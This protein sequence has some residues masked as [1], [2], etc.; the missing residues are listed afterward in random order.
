[1]TVCF[2]THSIVKRAE[3][4]A[5]VDSGATENFMNLGYAKW[6]R[7]PIKRLAFKQNL[8]NVDGMEN[9]SG[10]LKYYTDL[11][12]QMG[13][14]RV[15]M[16]FFL[17]DLGEHKV[18]LGYSWFVAMQPKIDWKN[19]WIDESQ[20]LIILWTE[21]SAKATYLPWQVN[22]PHPVH[23]DRYFLGKVM[24]SQATKD[25]M[26]GVPAEYE[27]HAKI[28]SEQESQRLPGHMVWDHAIELLPSAPMMLPGWLLP[29]TQEEIVEAQKFV[30]RH[31]EWGIIRPSWSPYAANFF[32]I[33]KKDGKLQPVQDYRL[34]NKWTKKNCNVSP[35]ILSVIDRLVGCTLFTK[36]DIQWGY[37]NIWIKPGDEWKA[38]FLTPEGLFKPTVMF[39]GLTNSPAIFQMM[40]NTIFQW[41]VQE[42]WFS[43]FMD[44]SIIY[45]KRWSGESKN[46]HRQRHWELVHRIFDILAKN[47]LYIKPEK[48]TFEQEEIEYLGIIVGKGKT[49]MDPKKLMAVANYLTLTT[50]TEVCAFLGLMGY[51]WYFIEGYSK[52]VWP[53]LDLMKKVEAWHWDK[54]QEQAFMDLKTRMCKALVLTQLNFNWKFYLQTDASGYSMG[55]ILLQEGGPDTLTMTLEQRKKLV[56]HPI[57]Y[58]LATFMPTQWNYD[59]YNRELLAIMMALDH[60]RQYL[61]WTKVLFTIMT[62]HANLQ[63]WK[64]PQNLT[65]CTVRWHLDLQEYNYEILYSTS[66]GKKMNHQMHYHNHQEWTKAKKITRA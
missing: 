17:M 45:T 11:E 13:A 34:V 58:Y 12:V 39:F 20:L 36:F 7:L 10:K 28:F 54:E 15:R 50:V 6:L 52:L 60:W 35:L 62:D 9:K 37:N 57:A 46:Q 38:T 29:L 43:I 32:F 40:M 66:Q 25:E 5:L 64:S 48:C 42:G 33:K 63:Y 22:V 16:W 30:K 55:A 61:G 3:G 23:K 56:L 41:E 8:Y 4:V 44:N 21:N 1:M 14:R 51:Y 19:G 26:K 49:H 2:Y 65:W 31:L 53:L 47:D 59:V 18:I 24:I 27:W